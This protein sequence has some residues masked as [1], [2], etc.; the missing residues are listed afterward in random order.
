MKIC[1][2]RVCGRKDPLGI[3]SRNLTFGWVIQSEGQN[4]RQISYHLVVLDGQ[5][6]CWDSGQV[7]SEESV[8]VEYAG[9]TLE[10]GKR[11]R[12]YVEAETS[13]GESA[14]SGEAFFELALEEHQRKALWIEPKMRENVKKT[15]NMELG[16]TVEFDRGEDRQPAS[17]LRKDFC[18]SKEV[19][20]AR[21]YVTAHGVY[22]AYINGKKADDR[23][24]APEYTSYYSHLLFQTYDVTKL[25]RRGK[26][27]VGVILEDGWWSG[28]VSGGATCTYGKKRALW[29]QME[30]EYVD[31]EKLCVCSDETFR[32][33]EGPIRFSD[34]FIGETYDARLEQPGWNLPGYAAEGW[35]S[36]HACT[37]KE[38]R[39]QPQ[40]N[41]PVRVVRRFRP[42][43]I[44]RAQNGDILLDAGENIAG[45]LTLSI[46]APRGTRITM[47]HTE[48]LDKEGNYF[49]NLRFVNNLQ[50]VT[51]ICKGEGVEVYHPYFSFQGFRYV[52][53][54]GEVEFSPEQFWVNVISSDNRQTGYF[55]CSDERLN[56]LQENIVRSQTANLISIP[57]DCPQRERAGWTG[58]IE[59]F[60]P[61]ACFNQDILN[62]M[63]KWMADVRC[64]QKENGA[65]PQ[66][67]PRD[68]ENFPN[69]MGNEGLAGWSDAC[70][71]VPY[72][73]YQRMGDR[74]ILRDN[75]QTM[76]KWLRYV[77]SR[78]KSGN[79]DEVK[80]SDL[81]KNNE[82]FRE[83]AG[84]LWDTDF[85]YGDWLIPSLTT[86]DVQSIFMGANMT[87]DIFATA[88]YAR[89]VQM[90][91]EIAGV[92]GQKEDQEYYGALYCKIKK[93]FQMW[94][95]RKNGNVT[96]D[97]QGAIVIGLQFGLIPEE[98]VE[99]NVALLLQ[100]IEEN[101]GCLDTGF[102]SVPYLLDALSQHGQ[103]DAAYRL[104][105]QEKCPSWLYEL[106]MGATT[107]WESWGAVSPDGQ[108]RACSYNHYAFGS[109]GDWM[110]RT[111]GGLVPIK[112]G[113][114]EFSIQPKPDE[115]LSQAKIIYD[116]PYGRIQAEWSRTEEEFQL[117]FQI[118]VNTRCKVILPDGT[119][120]EYGSGS[121]QLKQKAEGRM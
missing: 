25:L 72:T 3:G 8:Y 109:V 94:F 57:T 76:K 7:E 88:Y 100:K 71:I 93:A 15:V 103:T 4:L 9:K 12:W 21:M 19:R 31:G 50:M 61:T 98:Y 39:M 48:V 66:V 24:L 86:G 10:G 29:L 82:E 5:T 67:V 53:L 14:K 92:L 95:L 35:D 46:E 28:S 74:Q 59:V 120:G 51:Y 16:Q 55:Q 41:E 119:E 79:S 40:E 73:M 115:S 34:L 81:Y 80:N 75:Y 85:H 83:L 87:K 117:D 58:D 20:S 49:H 99:Q 11:Y 78:T 77:D 65:V 112:P 96:P 89:T 26:N 23:L 47:Q 13:D 69:M 56:R 38:C 70:I 54:T 102:L 33:S 68:P 37:E 52:R 6:I 27:A 118:P 101:G 107:V 44:F 64:D 121:Y 105:Y 108:P 60:C 111:I 97:F 106:N 1:D 113:Y 30:I 43:E 22:E 114:K 110:Y 45:F 104:L 91:A 32:C 90:M 63:K 2:L 62:F 17:Y 116:S 36:V 42:K 84:Y 18:C